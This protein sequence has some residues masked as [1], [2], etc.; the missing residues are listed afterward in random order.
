MT[1]MTIDRG[2]QLSIVDIKVGP[3]LGTGG[4]GRVFEVLNHP[5]LVFKQYYSPEVDAAALADLVRFPLSLPAG[6]ASMLLS[7]CAWPLASVVDGSGR[8]AGFVM[9]RV[10]D[11]FVGR[12]AAGP[13]LRELQYLLYAP[14][15]MW[16]AIVPL[17]PGQR[18]RL[19]LAVVVLFS[20]LHQ[21]RVVLGDVSMRNVLWSPGPNPGLYLIDCD[22]ARR[23]GGR[24][25]LPQPETVG[26]DDPLCPSVSADLDSDRYKLALI[27]G[28]VLAGDPD[29]R[30]GQE[31]RL[32][33][34][35][36]DRNR[37]AIVDCFATA[38]GPRGTRPDTDRWASALFG[39]AQVNL[40]APDLA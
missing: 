39:N 29:V 4:Q 16:S 11:E 1:A 7:R 9:P 14:K 28:R 18:L 19:A 23:E 3:L 8:V 35:L 21:H 37:A 34:Q 20:V 32:P 10:P 30:P 12:T 6:Q 31:L 25:P 36:P 24:S 33:A 26:W 17:G 13:T 22:S 38:G 27:V 5:G 15:P 40:R 2:Q